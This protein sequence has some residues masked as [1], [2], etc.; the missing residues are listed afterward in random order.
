MSLQRL[1]TFIEVYRQGSVSSAARALD[2]SQPAVSQHIAGLE[3]SIGRTLFERRSHG[4]VPSIAAHDLARDLG[5]RLDAAEM[6]LAAARVRSVERIGAIQIVGQSDFLSEFVTPQLVPLLDSGMQV[7]LHTAGPG[8]FEQML[9]NGQ[10][11]LGIAGFAITDPRLRTEYLLSQHVMAVAAPD[12]AKR[13]NSAEN[14]GRALTAE[15]LLGYA[16]ESSLADVWTRSHGFDLAGKSVAFMAHAL[17][18]VRMLAMSGY[19]WT[20]VPEYFCRSQ[21]AEGRLTAIMGPATDPVLTYYLVW[22]PSALR[23]PRTASARQEL[24]RAF[25]RL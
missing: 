4:V 8:Q 22:A 25:H 6:V 16:L 12:V 14:L 3:S 11:D 2:M 15:P 5:D 13:M 17:H 7:R 9:L 20:V 23:N 10:C 19:G 24:I 18:A 1:R 21:M